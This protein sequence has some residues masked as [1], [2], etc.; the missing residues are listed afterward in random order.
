MELG[1]EDTKTVVKASGDQ[2]VAEWEKQTGGGPTELT[3]YLSSHLLF[4]FHPWVSAIE[5][6]GPSFRTNG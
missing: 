5:D 3:D 1:L 4:S 6:I 2:P